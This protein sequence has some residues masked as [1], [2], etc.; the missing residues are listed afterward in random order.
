MGEG[1]YHFS[2]LR[3]AEIEG[4]STLTLSAGDALYIPSGWFY[5]IT[6]P[7]GVNSGV[8]YSWLPSDWRL[9]LSMEEYLKKN[10]ISKLSGENQDREL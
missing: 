9:T 7:P 5:E 3:S 6:A 1:N 2:S 4:G 8:T 10:L